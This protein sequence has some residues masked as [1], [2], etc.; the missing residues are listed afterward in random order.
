M[1]N[2]RASFG[3]TAPTQQNA[4][5][6]HLAVPRRII[7]K[8]Q[9]S[10]MRPLLARFRNLR[11][12][13]E[14]FSVAWRLESTVARQLWVLGCLFLVSSAGCKARNEKALLVAHETFAE[15]RVVKGRV[16]I[17]EAGKRERVPYPRERLGEGVK[18][19][20]EA[21]ALAYLRN[22]RGATWLI[23]GPTD[24]VVHQHQLDLTRGKIFV[25][26]Q[27]GPS[28][29]LGTSAGPL[30]IAG[31]RSSI[32]AEAGGAVEAY[33]L[34]GS[35]RHAATRA[36][37]GE[38]LRLHAGKPTETR[39]LTSFI[40]W[41]S[42]LATADAEAQPAPYGIGTV[43]ARPAGD[44][45][46]PRFP[47]VI[48]RLDV[49]VTINH[50]YARTEVDETF[51]NPSAN[52]VE[53]IFSFRVPE[54]G[55]LHRFGVDRDGL[56][57]WGRP[58]EKRTAAAKYEANVYA[59]SSE[60]PALLEWVQRGVYQARLYPIA[61]GSTRRVV[62]RYGEWLARTGEHGE[63]RAYVYPMAA[64]GAEGTLPRIEEMNI[65]VNWSKA[66][67]TRIRAPLGSVVRGQELILKAFDF[68]PQSDFA[69]EL[70]DRGHQEILAYRAK[71]ALSAEDAPVDAAQGFADKASREEADY[72][73]IPLARPKSAETD[74]GLDLSIVVDSSAATDPSALAVSR[75]L[76]EALLGSLGKTDRAALFAGDSTLRPVSVDSGQLAS[77]DVERKKI[78]LAALA[79]I[80][81][82]GATD[83]GTLLAEAAERLDAKRRGAVIYIGD[84][85][86]SVGELVP[87]ALGERLTR[88]PASAR[89]FAVGVGTAVNRALLQSLVRGAPLETAQNGYEA[90]H[91]ALRLLE[92]AS[93]PAWQNVSVTLAGMDR[94]LP[95]SVPTV[96]AGQ[97]ALLIGRVAGDSLGN[98]LE[99]A[100]TDGKTRV[101]VRIVGIDDDGDLRRRWGAE[102][103]NELVEQHTGRLAVVA[104]ARRYGLVTPLT[105][106][107]V[108]TRKEAERNEDK[109]TAGFSAGEE[110]KALAER[111]ARWRPWGL[112]GG[113]VLARKEPL[114]EVTTVSVALDKESQSV[115]AKEAASR[116]KE[117]GT[118]TRAKGEEGSLGNPAPRAKKR[119][120]IEPPGSDSRARA[121]ALDEA[122]EFGMIGLVNAAKSGAARGQ[123]EPT[124]DDGEGL[125]AE[126]PS[127]PA[128]PPRPSEPPSVHDPRL[129]APP[130][131]ARVSASRPKSALSSVRG[132]AAQSGS[133]TRAG[134]GLSSIGTGREKGSPVS[135]TS[136]SKDT[137]ASTKPIALAPIAQL[138]H[139]VAPCSPAS[140]LPLEER[141]KLWRERLNQCSTADE[142]RELYRNIIHGCEA[143]GWF[144]RQILLYAMV[145]RL[146]AVE[147]RVRLYRTF[148]SS[149][150]YA[151]VIYRAMLVRIQDAQALRRFEAAFGIK[152][153]ASELITSVL[154][155]A[156]NPKSRIELLLGLVAQWPNDL[157]LQL[158]LLEAY[159]DAGDLGAARA[160][161][162][163]L[164]RRADATSHVRTM[165]GEFYWR[166]SERAK[167]SNASEA[168]SN[169]EEARRSFGEIVEFAP[170][171]PAARRRLGDLLRAHGWYEEAL[172]QYETLRELLPDDPTVY[173][174]IAA[175]SQGIG[176][177]E[178]AL[179]WTERAAAT[180]APNA[181]ND[182]ERAA[183]ALAAVCLASAR[184]E[185]QKAGNPAD[186]E[187]LL[188]RGRNLAP[189]AELGEGQIRFVL[190]WEHPELRPTLYGVTNVGALPGR[191]LTALG[192]AEQL[193]T[194][195]EP[196]VEIRIEPEEALRIARLGAE[197]RLTA[198]VA[199]GTPQQQSSEVR[200]RFGD[201]KHPKPIL[202]FA[203]VDGALR[204]ETR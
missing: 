70:F 61:A 127:K 4:R 181:D 37:A 9:I 201:L 14:V 133:A 21:D 198:V 71:H 135:S 171:D 161:A 174:L 110:Q 7:Q 122:Q 114:P 176:K 56:L 197:I 163:R 191:Q 147:E 123:P 130:A 88:L 86:P 23:A 35:V 20:L 68:S 42:G 121:Q 38:M 84:G 124:D 100:G 164:R 140:D 34:R 165:V 195:E 131:V 66:S 1:H 53:G 41:T 17:T 115:L 78:W 118:G 185:A 27:G 48:Q 129:V 87:K 200:A 155:R 143:P 91:A 151:A 170:E 204:E 31:G 29:T 139:E 94:M 193:A 166:C 167:A 173:L 89:I 52:E 112:L 120:S 134:G 85:R 119:Y 79:N 99:V 73:M 187:R 11:N 57:V 16:S 33:V 152:N 28:V 141:R 149:P 60:D 103:Y 92:A 55:I 116:T 126:A 64:T 69:L 81:P 186:A 192:L 32:T 108:A 6:P 203:Y 12:S 184:S 25:D 202:R 125:E 194:K 154:S 106:L 76:V 74:A 107:Y 180:G 142:A 19:S 13:R 50:D 97:P 72:L 22:D 150:D 65:R 190:S 96:G 189:A 158:Q 196:R 83:L 26:S 117:G 54:N 39:K 82:G 44:Q 58:Q 111:Q 93:M 3:C 95:R 183:Q 24:A 77:M 98:V 113:G 10:A 169:L 43:G 146:T 15:L 8:A 136:P 138:S 157:E 199:A 75:S 175:T 160:L 179:R 49:R 177:T 105:S 144:E 145:D 172:R 188:L 2:H 159:E 153:A 168:A 5:I 178:E 36:E 128:S 46:K 137:V 40:D 101:P 59:G 67:A 162:R 63:R 90:A 102:R 182:L 62:T 156:K 51:V 18:L 30:E 148:L 47:L 45:G 104:L 80:P 109:P 132:G